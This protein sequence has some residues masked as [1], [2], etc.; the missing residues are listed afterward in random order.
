M[1]PLRMLAALVLLFGTGLLQ[2]D[3]LR[4]FRP[5]SAA[6]IRRAHAGQPYLLALWSL[7]CTYCAEE[8]AML[9]RLHQ[10]HP[11]LTLVLVSTDTSDDQAALQAELRRHGLERAE[12]WVFADDFS[13]RLRH[14]L[15]PRWYGELPRSYLY[16]RDGS[17]RAISGKPD[18]AELQD[19]L[20]TQYP[21]R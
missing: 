10:N 18:V 1:K 21:V 3:P 2:A 4:P 9:G 11:Q 16:G 7:T 20:A 5:G 19:W 15:D 6:E 12:A 8:M 13:E 14:E 17:A